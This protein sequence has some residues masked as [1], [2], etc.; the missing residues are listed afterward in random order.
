VNELPD[1]PSTRRSLAAA[2]T[3]LLGSLRRAIERGDPRLG[4]FVGIPLAVAVAALF[5][6]GLPLARR[7]D[8]V[9]LDFAFRLRPA[10]PEAPEVVHIDMDD[11]AVRELGLIT[12]RHQA[13]VVTAL[14]RLG[15]KSIV[16][17]VQ[18]KTHIPR[19]GDFDEAGGDFVL[20]EGTRELAGAIGRSGR[21]TLGYHSEQQDPVPSLRPHFAR[22]KEA[23]S[24]DLSLDPAE[25]A[26]RS[27]VETRVFADEMEKLRL[28]VAL[29]LA[30]DALRAAPGLGFAE[31]RKSVLPE[32]D[33]RNVRLVQH[34][35]WV[36]RT[37]ALLEGKGIPARVEGL[38]PNPASGHS[39]VPPLPVLAAP[40]RNGGLV[41]A[42]ADRDGVLRR[43]WLFFLRDGRPHFYLGFAAGVL[44]MAAE[45]ERPEVLVRPREVVV[46]MLGAD[47]AARR[48]V[49]LP[50]EE[51]GRLLVS[52]A[53]NAWRNRREA[54]GY[55][56][57]LPYLQPVSFYE[58]RYV[59]LDANAR[60][61][62]EQLDEETQKA[63]GAA[64][65]LAASDR[66]REALRG[67]A[68]LKP[69]EFRAAEARMDAVRKAI[70][71]GFKG[72]EREIVEQLPKIAS[73]RIRE[74]TEKSLA[75][76]R[77][78]IASLEGPLERERDLRRLVEG[79]VCFI[80]AAYTG[81][82]DLHS[83]P[84]G[85]TPGVDVHSN[86]AN[87]VLTGRGIRRAGSAANFLFL[88]AVGGL[89]SLA[90]CVWRTSVAALAG[91]A[92][93]AAAMGVYF[94]LFAG[95]SVLLAGFGPVAEWLFCFASVA[96]FKELVTERSKRKLQREL[97]KNT[98]PE[99][100][101]IILEHPELLA[102]PR[103]MTGTF[104]FSDV[105]SF[106]SISEKMTANVL[107]PFINRYLDCAT[108]ALLNHRAYIDKY[109]GDGIMALFGVP[110]ASP[111]HAVDACLAALDCQAAIRELNVAFAAEGLPQVTARIGLNSGE[112]N[113]GNVGASDRSNYTVLGDAVNLASRLEGANKEY[114][115]LIM[116]SES[117][118]ALVRGRF[119]V[120]ELDCIRVVGKSKA[121]RIYELIAPADAPM[122]LPAGFV[123]AYEAA[124]AAYKLRRWDEAVEGFGKALALKPGDRPSSLY[125]ER[126]AA[127]RASPP[128]ADW[129]GV[130][131]LTSK[132]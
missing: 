66:V 113:A 124:L 94:A 92:L 70:L 132:G 10:V 33:A 21:V 12:R 8:N 4:L 100:V 5:A 39:F 47:S 57:H 93:L 56:V 99:L 114:D 126:A 123:E 80:G 116:L 14:D 90:V 24:K 81:S 6:L 65:Y 61:F 54:Q 1:A 23:L 28:H 27:G 101:R 106:T 73:P 77:A 42:E 16:F 26:R 127:F 97:E 63:V 48:S 75:G 25:L 122:P 41:N 19:T 115:T 58:E 110:V 102:K 125:A 107:F 67:R 53:G 87:M 112:V 95:R 129:D 62:I 32:G 98:S 78:N 86:V 83:T 108:R 34:A 37:T 103:R 111:S 44:G 72:A 13:Q 96:A 91:A 43:P 64:D 46:R 51:E 15:A 84:L 128:P 130:F 74:R 104:F 30:E 59:L 117:T 7:L 9:V 45:G 109:I 2:P 50:L 49:T 38:P 85:V 131:V 29:S 60:K 52:W 88:A 76:I 118:E 105:K 89:V 69:A 82:G 3:G 119:V 120:R 22:F 68:E 17:D 35:Y 20:D 121:V 55:F 79:R 18:F 36:A 71:D 31:F 11:P 40:A